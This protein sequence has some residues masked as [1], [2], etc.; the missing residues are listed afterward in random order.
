MSTLYVST[1]LRRLVVERAGGRCE[2]CLSPQA[3][4]LASHEI[5][6]IIPWKH[7]GLTTEENLALSCSLCNK[8]KGTDFA[9]FHPDTNEIV[10][11]FHPR[12]ERWST[13]FSLDDSAKI[14]P[15]I[16]I[17]LV[18][19]QLLQF[20]RTDRLSERRLLLAL[21]LLVESNDL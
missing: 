13:H 7:G 2:Y 1:A 17:G 12:R 20:N 10:A 5:D 8:H 14:L 21:D 6:H 3:I 9:S 11:L 19:I 16:D 4:A 18:T 15:H